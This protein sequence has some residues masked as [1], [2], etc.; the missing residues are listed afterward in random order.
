M[1]ENPPLLAADSKPSKFPPTYQQPFEIYQHA[2]QGLDIK[3]LTQNPGFDGEASFSKDGKTIFFTRRHGQLLDIRSMASTGKQVLRLKGPALPSS[4]YV[5]SPDGK[6]SAW[7]EWDKEYA[8]GRLKL[9]SPKNGAQE[10]AQNMVVHKT[11]L[12]FSPDS[13]W[14]LWS[15]LNTET[16]TY[17]LWAY[18]IQA[19][20]LRRLTAHR[21][22]HRRDPVISP[23]MKWLAYTTERKARSRIVKVPFAP[24]SSPCVI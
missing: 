2:L 22:G 23:D 4:S 3:R 14:L 16:S 20:C 7:V 9:R 18:E 5:V 24:E 13:R 11:D 15:Q 21:D 8:V 1:K 6:H 10:L 12:Q 17:Q 19:Q